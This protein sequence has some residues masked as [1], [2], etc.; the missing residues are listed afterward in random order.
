MEMLM[1]PEYMQQ[2][3]QTAELNWVKA[4]QEAEYLHLMQVLEPLYIW[5]LLTTLTIR[6]ETCL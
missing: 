5:Q 6:A 3:Q 4:K 2:A 1:I